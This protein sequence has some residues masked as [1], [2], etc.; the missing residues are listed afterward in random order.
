[1]N[2]MMRY[3]ILALLVLSGFG[4]AIFGQKT[5]LLSDDL[6]DFR[7]ATS[8]YE[9]QQ[10]VSAQVIFNE[11]LER[12]KPGTVASDCAYWSAKC[13]IKSDQR[14]GDLLMQKFLRENPTSTWSNAANLEVGRHYFG[15]GNYEKAISWFD[16]VDEKNLNT[17]EKEQLAFQK[18]Y[19]FFV[20]K[21]SKKAIQYLERVS[22]S[23]Q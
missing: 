20:M 5:A 7:L 1:M 6:R 11:I 23:E 17:T 19:G 18:G 14:D 21:D 13:A 3:L 22:N 8:L 16:K 10:Y 9:D 2:K 4:T 15:Q 12:E